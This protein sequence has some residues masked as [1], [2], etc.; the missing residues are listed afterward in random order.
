METYSENITMSIKDKCNYDY[1]D[2][3][4]EKKLEILQ[5][6][7][8]CNDDG[9][10]FYFEIYFDNIGE[11]S[12]IIY[13]FNCSNINDFDIWYNYMTYEN[14]RRKYLSKKLSYR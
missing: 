13:D 11:K 10:Q 4:I 2:K 1:L 8:V 5:N 9:H 7:E 6:A 12:S 14:D 3:M